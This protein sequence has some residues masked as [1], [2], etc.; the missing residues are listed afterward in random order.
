[1][2]GNF[3]GFGD[4]KLPRAFP[5]T[6]DALRGVVRVDANVLVRQIG[7]PEY[8]RAVSLVKVDGD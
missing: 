1:M 3:T 8:A 7:G 4:C 6:M 2:R 5:L